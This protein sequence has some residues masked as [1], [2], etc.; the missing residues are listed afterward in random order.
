MTPCN[1]SEIYWT[2]QLQQYHSAKVCNILGYVCTEVRIISKV[3]SSS[4]ALQLFKFG[5]GFLSA[6]ETAFHLKNEVSLMPNPQ[7]GSRALISVC[8]ILGRLTNA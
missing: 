3:S 6:F 1:H 7:S 2:G 4:V 8:A 5:F